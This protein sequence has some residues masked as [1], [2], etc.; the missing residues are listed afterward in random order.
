MK[1]KIALDHIKHMCFKIIKKKAEEY[2]NEKY[3]QKLKKYFLE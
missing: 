1:A 2:V 3:G